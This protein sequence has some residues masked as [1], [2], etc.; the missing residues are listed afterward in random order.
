METAHARRRTS[1]DTMEITR[2]EIVGHLEQAGRTEDAARARTEL[3]ESFDIENP[4]AL[5][6]ELGVDPKQLLS[7]INSGAGDVPDG[8][9]EAGGLPGVRT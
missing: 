8:V 6:T 2:D 4:P 1:E 3:P 5:V 9:G 7:D